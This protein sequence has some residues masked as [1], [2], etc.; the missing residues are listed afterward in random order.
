M[1]HLRIA[2]EQVNHSNSEA[3]RPSFNSLLYRPCAEFHGA[4]HLQGG[5]IKMP[6]FFGYLLWSGGILLRFL[7]EYVLLVRQGGDRD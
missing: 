3:A 4:P 6:S 5:G 2:S 1:T 7:L